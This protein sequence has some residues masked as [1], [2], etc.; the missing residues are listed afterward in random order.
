[1][2]PGTKIYCFG[3]FRLNPMERLLLRNQAPVHLSP[4]AFDAL[5]V[6]VKN[7][8]HLLEKDELLQQ[9]WPETFVEESNLA[10]HIS[11]LRK[12]LQDGEEGVRYIETVPRR[13]YRFVAEVREI[14][15]NGF[16]PDLHLAARVAQAPAAAEPATHLSTHRWQ[17]F[18]GIGVVL[19]AGLLIAVRSLKTH[20]DP[21]IPAPIRSLAVL[22]LQNLSGDTSQ[23]YFADGMTEALITDL[24]KIPDLK[25]ISRTSVMRYKDA[26]KSL[27]EIG[28]DLAVDA[29][30][31]GAVVRFG[32]TVRITAQLIRASNDQHIWAESYERDMADLVALQDDVSRDIA[33]QI[34]K[35]VQ[36]Q[37]FTQ[38]T[39]STEVSA[40][41]YENYLK[42]RYFWNQ[43]SQAG[44]LKAIEHFQ[45]AVAEDPRYAK[46]Y[47]GLA[48]AY[49]LLGSLPGTTIPRDTAMP[50]A[51]QAALTALHLDDSLA[52]AHTSLAFVEMHYEWKFA[53]AEQEFKRA[54]A[55]NP[56]YST[57]HQWYAFDLAATGRTGE[58]V[59]EMKR[60][61][62][63]DPL[64]L[65]INTDLAEMLY[66]DRK[67]DEA[68]KQARTTADLDPNFPLV[69][70]MLERIHDQKHMFAE[71]IA[72]GQR[73]AALSQ[74]NP[75]MLLELASTYALAGKKTE[76]QACLRKAAHLSV[77]GVL[78]DDDEMMTEIYSELGENDLAFSNMER[79]F[80]GHDGG[81]IL[82]NTEPC[83]D[84][85]RSDSRFKQFVQRVGL[86]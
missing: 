74:D 11:L 21:V 64:S 46:A 53:E 36:P 4:K 57:A 38:F 84:R 31:E 82:L 72:E 49:A 34:E 22:P 43:R 14:D 69:Y 60:A 75:W 23:E 17:W 42:G 3:P 12:A 76:M 44:Y 78:P 25:V 54:I 24:A 32:K 39:S 73:G 16:Q 40:E 65:I 48:D 63:S 80:H 66:F 51:K 8:G 30:V 45:Q 28:R 13:G 20:Q 18:A 85:L 52:D 10:Q 59:A 29:V 1:M 71:A 26:H 50:E 67:Y 7:G 77:G 62:Q 68:L 86:S 41:A 61:Q 2:A 19:A 6:L 70:R 83:Y 5:S 37:R 33:E 47:A 35:E 9:V 56:N 58:A 15:G 55:L 27:P 81:L 79:E